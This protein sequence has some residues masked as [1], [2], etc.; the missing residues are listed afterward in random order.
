[1]S[2]PANMVIVKATY[3]ISLAL[4][5]NELW[6]D[7]FAS[8][9]GQM[10]LR[11][12]HWKSASR[13]AIRTI[14]ELDV[15]LI[16]LGPT[17][18]STDPLNIFL[19]GP[20]LH[21]YFMICDDVD[22][23]R[24]T[25]RKQVQEWRQSIATKTHQDWL[26]VLLVKPDVQTGSKRLFQ[27]KSTVL[28]KIKSD[29]M[30]EKRERCV[31]LQWAPGMTDPVPWADFLNRIKEGIISTIDSYV[32][33]LEEEAKK[34]E[35]QR[36]HEG[37]EFCAFCAIKDTLAS[38]FERM[39]LWEDTIV[40]LD[41]L[42]AYLYQL[43]NGRFS[44]PNN[45]PNDPLQEWGR[46]PLRSFGG[47]GVKDDSLPLLSASK[48]PYRDLIV[49]KTISEF[50]FRI[51]LISRQCRALARVGDVTGSLRK[52]LR[53]IQ[54]FSR[55]MLQNG[56]HPF[57][58]ESW[59][60]SGSLNVVDMSQT[61]TPA[62]DHNDVVQKLSGLR[63][64]LLELA[65]LQ[66]DK[67][68]M[69]SGHLPLSS[70]FT[71]ALSGSSSYVGPIDS[72]GR[73]VSQKDLLSAVEQKDIFDKL[74]TITTHRAIECFTA[75]NR[76]RA[77]LKLH[78]YL[79]AFDFLR[80][81][82]PAASL[83]F[84]SLP[85]HYAGTRWMALEG[86][87]RR[88]ALE[89]L[90]HSAKPRDQDWVLATL[91]F[92]RCVVALESDLH[93]THVLLPSLGHDGRDAHE[94][95]SKIGE[96]LHFAASQLTKEVT[97]PSDQ[98]VSLKSGCHMARFDE[99]S[100]L[101]VIPLVIV[102][103]LPFEVLASRVCIELL[104]G[105]GTRPVRY[106]FSSD[107]GKLL[108]G[109]NTLEVGQ[110]GQLLVESV[111]IHIS[112]LTLRLST[113]DSR[114]I[115]TVFIPNTEQLLQARLELPRHV[116]IGK[117]SFVIITL[118]S[119]LDDVQDVTI[120][121]EKCQKD[122]NVVYLLNTASFTERA[123]HH[124]YVH[125][126]TLTKL[127][128]SEFGGGIS[129]ILPRPCCHSASSSELHNSCGSPIH[130]EHCNFMPQGN[131]TARHLTSGIPWNL[132][133]VGYRLPK[134]LEHPISYWQETQL[135][136]DFPVIVNV[137]EHI[138]HQRCISRFTV[139]SDGTHWV[140][141]RQ[142][143]LN[144]MSGCLGITS[145]NKFTEEI[146]TPT[147]PIDFLFLIRSEGAG[148]QERLTFHL[149]Y[150][151]LDEELDAVLAHL[152][153][154][155]LARNTFA[156]RHKLVIHQS[157]K[158]AVQQSEDWTRSYLHTKVFRVGKSYQVEHQDDCSK[159]AQ[160]KNL[161]KAYEP[162]LGCTPFSDT[163]PIISKLL[164]SI[165]S[166]VV[167]LS[168]TGNYAM[169]NWKERE[170]ILP[171]DLPAVNVLSRVDV[172]V[173]DSIRHYAGQPVDCKVSILTLF[174]HRWS[175]MQLEVCRLKYNVHGTESNA[176]LISGPSRGE[177]FGKDGV[178]HQFG[179]SLIPLRHG[180]LPIPSVEVR[181]VLDADSGNY[182]HETYQKQ[183]ATRVQVLPRGNHASFL[184]SLPVAERETD[185]YDA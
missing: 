105:N 110:M 89:I 157:I 151:T 93:S 182:T 98:L 35:G 61:W 111:S 115:S 164:P 16:P 63:G 45:F 171:V 174:Q 119:G 74:Y 94:G 155:R 122:S 65:K 184:V 167:D 14:Q 142:V 147:Q 104:R 172:L 148:V 60:Y 68:G 32:L 127:S 42:E 2:P 144:S 166:I 8:I 57:F 176:W 81:K 69:R 170:M 64:E 163:V 3:T 91:S 43:Y 133:Q 18:P 31:Q 78:G 38:L 159:D 137:Q 41:E 100:R 80:N 145:N 95:F 158:E 49:M 4:Q 86:K 160:W 154:K 40:Q 71:I 87:M 15:D 149:V 109:P 66:L 24:A 7:L 116:E 33:V 141:I 143:S 90:K 9:T 135:Q 124:Q 84:T 10:P 165:R 11:N 178:Q 29:F 101:Y 113:Q 30:T 185:I 46:S 6:H 28:D 121:L 106:T 131:A 13:P 117:P 126:M 162:S 118:E 103:N 183:A 146:L 114:V 120:V 125:P 12:L 5:S 107:D 70:P 21:I 22:Q 153:N 25:E 58:V 23:Y 50:D 53:F 59:I 37:W 150:R 181:P 73:L 134:H 132:E 92:L 88:H 44:S 138:R 123:S 36:H 128:Q 82:S 112:K 99:Q 17:E 177:Y 51:F 1:M 34:C 152:E 47:L 161:V 156:Q 102:N 175:G 19:D 26:I 180:S 56:L 67:I 62:S 140:R 97:V 39:G 48:K 52:C 173:P 108:Q 27:K 136:E 75:G 169:D 72:V 168:D 76:K 139:S 83:A 77:A 54:T 85:P 79:A 129:R 55:T 179:L 96:A 130:W 20:F